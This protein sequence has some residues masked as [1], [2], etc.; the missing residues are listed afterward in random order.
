MKNHIT[1]I[2][3]LSILMYNCSNR[4][5][6]S[7][8][9]GNFEAQEVLIS[10]ETPGKII[11]FFVEEGQKL[12]SGDTVGL[13]DTIPLYLQKQQLLAAIEAVRTKKSTVNAQVELLKEQKNTLLVEKD[14]IEKL[15]RDGAATTQQMDQIE[16]QLKTLNSQIKSTETQF[17]GL[18]S[19][20]HSIEVQ[21]E[22]VSDKIRRC[23]IINPIHGTV[24][25]KYAEPYEMAVAGR[26]LYK[27]ADLDRMNLR[28]YVSGEQLPQI[29]LGQ[30][31]TVLID[32]DS[33]TNQ[34][35]AGTITWISE[36]SEF[37]PKIIQTKEER[38]NLVYAVKIQVQNDGSIKIGMPG[39]VRF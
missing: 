18:D 31:V 15:L 39:E 26:I 17:A 14:R 34:E 5:D 23:F 37:T 30:E 2:I 3:I 16:G 22:Q 20:I 11:Y 1:L 27:I 24:L 28:A 12:R 32:R 25:E 8:A 4:N 6:I 29:Q 9:Y 13:I 7:D 19:E 33:Q 36:K 38:V 35:L 10:S 21:I